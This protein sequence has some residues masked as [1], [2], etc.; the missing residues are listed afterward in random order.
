MHLHHLR[1]TTVG[2]YCLEDQI[3]LS[4]WA[5]VYRAHHIYSGHEAAVKL[6]YIDG[7][8]EATAR[9]LAVFADLMD[10][11]GALRDAEH[12][13]IL[14]IYE[15][16]TT[17]LH[18][19]MF[20][21]S[22]AAY[23]AMQYAAHGAIGH[24]AGQVIPVPLAT[25]WAAQAASALH[26]AHQRGIVHCNIKP[27]NVLLAGTARQHAMISD[28]HMNEV[29]LAF[30]IT[31]LVEDRQASPPE[32]IAPEVMSG[33]RFGPA[34]DIYSLA[35]VLYLMLAGRYPFELR[36]AI[37]TPRQLNSSP[38][39]VRTFNSAVPSEL[40]LVLRCALATRPAER[41]RTAEQFS[42]ALRP[43]ANS[44][45][46]PLRSIGATPASGEHPASSQ[47]SSGGPLPQS[48]QR[49]PNRS[50]RP[51]SVGRIFVSHS[52][53]DQMFCDDLV[54][55]LL[56]CGADDVWYDRRDADEPG[57]VHSLIDQGLGASDHFLLVWTHAAA[58]SA[59]VSREIGAAF[60][61]EDKRKIKN[62]LV[63]VEGDCELP[64][65]LLGYKRVPV[66]TEKPESAAYAAVKIMR[67]LVESP[68]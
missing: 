63:L 54:D 27:S 66:S 21:G 41:F 37:P 47:R 45:T 55:A 28:F 53:A 59:W 64:P 35:S 33:A 2:S 4:R 32:V 5:Q 13:A 65:V 18:D 67:M 11:L 46:A 22:N 58:N 56:V 44:V 61:L 15:Y 19:D 24:F 7:S 51:S 16:G 60:E 50:L 3:G 43:F 31:T 12:A 9:N 6:M 39:D 38:P 49:R 26:F 30:N 36:G 40:S 8:P 52:S 48:N 62:V 1:G 42:E 34:S 25:A 68:M 23:I 14:P 17:E 57:Q 20:G 29:K 10:R